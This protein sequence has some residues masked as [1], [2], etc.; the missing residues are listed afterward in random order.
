MRKLSDLSFSFEDKITKI[1]PFYFLK[2]EFPLS[3][4]YKKSHA[5]EKIKNI[6]MIARL[7][8]I[9]DQETLLKAFSNLKQLR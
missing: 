8:D 3:K 7:D 4:K 6:V 5:K 9:K 2:V 1:W